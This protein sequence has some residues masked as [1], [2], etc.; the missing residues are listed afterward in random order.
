M[1]DLGIRSV[2]VFAIAM[3]VFVATTL[4]LVAAM[5]QRATIRHVENLN[6]GGGL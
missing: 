2:I 1:N 6:R 4:A 3:L 5:E